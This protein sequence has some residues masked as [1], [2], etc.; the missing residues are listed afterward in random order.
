MKRRKVKER[1]IQKKKKGRTEKRK[2]ITGKDGK[3]KKK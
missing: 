1:Q 3:E 2:A